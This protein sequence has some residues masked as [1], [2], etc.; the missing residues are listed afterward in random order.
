[1]IDKLLLANGRNP[2]AFCNICLNQKST[3][4]KV[5][6][7]LL[8]YLSDRFLNRLGLDYIG[9]NATVSAVAGIINSVTQ[10]NES[11]KAQLVSWCITSSGAG[12]GH[13][14]SIRRAVLC[15]LAQDKETINTV[16]EKSLVQFGDELYIK[17]AA[18]LQQNGNLPLCLNCGA[19]LNKC[20]VH[21]EVLLLSAGYVFRL[22]PMK[23]TMLLRSGTYLSAISNRI[24]AT[25]VRARFLGLIVGE[26][27]SALVD[28]NDKKLDFHT[29]EMDTHDVERLKS[30]VKVSDQVGSVDCIMGVGTVAAT[31]K[32]ELT[33][34][35]PGKKQK[36]SPRPVSSTKKPK[37][38]IKEVGAS[39]DEEGD[40]APYAKNTDPEDSDEDP[41]LIQRSKLRPPVYIRD[42]IAFLRDSD[43]YHKQKLGLQ[44]APVLIRR[45][46]NYGTEVSSH[47]DELAGLLVGVQDKFEIENFS[48]LKLQGMVALIVAQPKTMAPWFARTFFEGDYSLSQRT[49]VL[50]SLGL[51]ARELAGFSTSEYQIGSSFPSKQLPEKMEQLYIKSTS[52]SYRPPASRLK[53]LPSTA[54]DTI[55]K[56]I[57]SIFLAPIAAE[58][59]DNATGPGVL[60]LETFTARYK[61]R[62]TKKPHARAIPN[63]A[64]SLLASSIFS[65]LTAH[66]QVAIRSS[67][68]VILNPALLGLYLQ[69]L[70]IILHAAGPSTLSISQLTSE[71]WDLLLGVRQHVL[72]DL[73]ASKGW[74][75]AMA[76]LMAVNEGDL[77]RLCEVQGR[78]VVETRAWVSGVFERTRGEDGGEENEVK[79]LAAGVLIKIGEAIEK[80]QAL[81]MGDMIGGP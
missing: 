68:P 67:K 16:L 19:L 15:V 60:K 70:G 74:L 52:Q 64:A 37:A 71:L 23:L 14:L 29:E 1:M 8:D 46:A 58:A 56:S 35:R 31:T 40:L 32:S 73:G 45:K 11:I 65:P 72:G 62:S 50:V 18:V 43:T 53:A 28:T 17:H 39:E 36:P 26:C 44:T 77:R 47:A 10:G 6:K 38:I 41:E 42:L 79:M 54:L 5:V 48:E 59:A 78:E 2:T 63:T 21:A 30:L 24:A 69:T 9:P 75:I 22:S 81:L 57:T 66:F 3:A 49:A 61:S 33:K 7:T 20:I 4:K 34:K 51:S 80:Y 13:G 12:L 27:F 76:S 55:T 25:Q